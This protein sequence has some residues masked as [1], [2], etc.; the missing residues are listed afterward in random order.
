MVF[1]ALVVMAI[2]GTDDTL[3]RWF[4]GA[5]QKCITAIAA[6]QHDAKPRGKQGQ[7]RGKG[8]LMMAWRGAGA[9]C[10]K[11]ERQAREERGE[12]TVCEGEERRRRREGREERP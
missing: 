10:R 7:T 4:Y 12:E 3:A 1:I 9:A 5:G 6:T 8:V 11:R 2:G